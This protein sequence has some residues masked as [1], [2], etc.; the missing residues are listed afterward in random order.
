MEIYLLEYCKEIDYKDFT[1]ENYSLI[2]VYFSENEAQK[3][4]E[5]IVSKK[6]V[7]EEHLFV[8]GTNIGK[9]QWEGGL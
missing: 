5:N 3:A 2:G 6:K 1:V 9:L 4:K 7:N 8:S